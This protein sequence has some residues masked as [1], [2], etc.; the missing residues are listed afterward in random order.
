MNTTFAPTHRITFTPATGDARVYD[1]CLCDGAAYTREEWESESPADWE[2]VDGAWRCQG[3]VT[4]GGANGTVEVT[5]I[6]E[7][8]EHGFT[9]TYKASA[10][11]DE[12]TRTTI[13]RLNDEDAGFSLDEVL[14]NCGNLECNADLYDAAGFRRGWVHADGTYTLN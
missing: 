9:V 10:N 14:A 5:E 8:A 6:D 2:C 11:A 7:A 1:V 4:P 3:N 13:A 12:Y